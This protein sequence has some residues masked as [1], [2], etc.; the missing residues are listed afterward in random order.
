MASLEKYMEETGKKLHK[1]KDQA[2]TQSNESVEGTHADLR[3][4][5]ELNFQEYDLLR[6]TDQDTSERPH[7][8]PHPQPSR[9]VRFIRKHEVQY[10]Y[11]VT[12]KMH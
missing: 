3:K 7:P 5:G 9:R 8:Q 6:S 11:L 10:N 2:D 4:E 12:P 1:A